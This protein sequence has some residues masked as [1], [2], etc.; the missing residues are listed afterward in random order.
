MRRNSVL[1]RRRSRRPNPDRAGSAALGGNHDRQ[2][3][4]APGPTPAEGGAT[5]R[6]LH[7]GAEAMGTLTALIMGLEC[8]LHQISTGARSA[9]VAQAAAFGPGR[10]IHSD[11]FCKGHTMYTAAFRSRAQPLP[12]P[13]LFPPAH[14]EHRR[15][16]GYSKGRSTRGDGGA[17]SPGKFSAV[18]P[19]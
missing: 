9:R 19:T 18:T 7:A 17:P 6:G 15:R 3:L 8:T 13:P 16:I 12:P 5:T 2:A 11:R 1:R 4:P 10:I 14:L